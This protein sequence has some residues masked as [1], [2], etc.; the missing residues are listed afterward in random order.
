[1]PRRAPIL[2]RIGGVGI[3][4]RED[5]DYTRYGAAWRVGGLA[6]GRTTG[7]AL[8]RGGPAR[9]AAQDVTSRSP[10]SQRLCWDASRPPPPV[11]V[12]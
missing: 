5:T 12:V 6:E 11:T 3:V 7:K 8:A 10:D 4:R 2:S 1:M 9:V